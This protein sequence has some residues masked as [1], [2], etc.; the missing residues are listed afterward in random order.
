MDF[1]I[2]RANSLLKR[3]LILAIVAGN[4]SFTEP[5]AMAAYP[6]TPSNISVTA[7][8]RY[9]DITWEA[10]FDNGGYPIIGYIVRT[11]GGDL[12]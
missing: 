8:D 3:A 1:K 12:M 2:F 10:P 4:F 11:Q 5:S 9:V 6:D 7:G